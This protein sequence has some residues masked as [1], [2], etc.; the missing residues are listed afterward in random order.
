MDRSRVA[1]V[2]DESI[3]RR[4]VARGLEK[5]N[6]SV[7]SFADGESVL[8]R[9]EEAAFDLLV[10]SADQSQLEAALLRHHPRLLGG[11]IRVKE[12]DSMDVSVREGG[13]R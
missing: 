12:K 2:D 5:E 7:E 3:V 1:V 10:L 6:L 9:L 4:E 13:C 11:V 8:E